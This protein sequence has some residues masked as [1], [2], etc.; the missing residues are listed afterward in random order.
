MIIMGYK[1]FVD[2]FAMKR[3]ADETNEVHSVQNHFMMND[4][5]RW[6][7]YIHTILILSSNCMRCVLFFSDEIEETSGVDGWNNRRPN[8]NSEM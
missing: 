2:D 7:N 3:H 5:F 4:I 1:H 8:A 6:W